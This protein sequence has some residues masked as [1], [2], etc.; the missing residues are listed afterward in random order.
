VAIDLVYLDL[1]GTV[2][3]LIS[4]ERI[5]VDPASQTEH[6]GY[7]MIALEVDDMKKRV[8]TSDAGCEIRSELEKSRHRPRTLLHHPT[9]IA[10]SHLPLQS[11]QDGR[12]YHVAIDNVFAT[13]YD[14]AAES[15]PAALSTIRT[16]DRLQLCGKLFTG[17]G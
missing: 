3:E 9:C 1:G 5:P 12:S 6:F 7:R 17:A 16:G 13:G 10:S 8:L 11:D 4:Y 15:V 14:A 2:V